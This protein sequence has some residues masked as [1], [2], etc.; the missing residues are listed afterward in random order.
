MR[1]ITAR[2]LSF[3]ERIKLKEMVEGR[4]GYEPSRRAIAILLSYS[5]YAPDH[6]GLIISMHVNHVMKWIKRFNEHGIEG[7]KEKRGGG[8]PKEYGPEMEEEVIKL[9]IEESPKEG[10]V[11]TLNKLQKAFGGK[12]SISTIRRIL[13]KRGYA[14]GRQNVSLSLK[15]LSLR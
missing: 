3:E 13:Q 2:P 1:A 12:P 6:I 15:T 10:G 7:I 14:G 4:D 8:R 11:W 5:G 9:V